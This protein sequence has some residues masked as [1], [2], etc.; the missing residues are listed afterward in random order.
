[1]VESIWKLMRNWSPC[2]RTELLQDVGW[3]RQL[4]WCM[5][6]TNRSLC[7]NETA[8]QSESKW[9]THLT[10]AQN[11]LSPLWWSPD[12]GFVLGSA[13]AFCSP[14]TGEVQREFLWVPFTFCEFPTVVNRLSRP[15][16]LAQ[17]HSRWQSR[18]AHSLSSTL[19]ST[20][21]KWVWTKVWSNVAFKSSRWSGKC[22]SPVSC[23]AVLCTVWQLKPFL[24]CLRDGFNCFESALRIV[25]LFEMLSERLQTQHLGFV[26]SYSSCLP[27]P[28]NP[29]RTRRSYHSNHS[30]FSD[31]LS[32]SAINLWTSM[33]SVSIIGF[34]PGKIQPL[35]VLERTSLEVLLRQGGLESIDVY[36]QIF[37]VCWYHLLCFLSTNPRKTGYLG[38]Y[39]SFVKWRCNKSSKHELWSWT[40][41]T[42]CKHLIVVQHHTIISF[43]F[44]TWICCHL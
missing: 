6:G 25:G 12:P 44:C 22:W 21:D 11:W 17:S 32:I 38:L 20:Q 31:I 27:L 29:D 16:P 3:C 8:H 13:R 26:S 15:M 1:M 19:L 5:V 9:M 41:Q 39:D 28:T 35:R 18:L 34:P 4:W 43:R 33:C 24:F 10:G 42:S 23:I 30:S 40:K 36:S 14:E 37:C 7:L 2:H